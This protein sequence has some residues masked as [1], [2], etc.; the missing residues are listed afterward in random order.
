MNYV[1]DDE[2]SEEEEEEKEP[3]DITIDR[4]LKRQRNLI[5]IKQYEDDLKR[6][7]RFLEHLEQQNGGK[8]R[9]IPAKGDNPY[10]DLMG[11]VSNPQRLLV[12]LREKISENDGDDRALFH[13][14]IDSCEHVLISRFKKFR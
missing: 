5:P 2:E 1:D 4:L 3:A 8:Y 11:V 12:R 13:C 7:T 9:L 10:Q 6:A 14:L